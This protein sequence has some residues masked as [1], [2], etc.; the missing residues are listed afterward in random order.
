MQ[1]VTIICDLCHADGIDKKAVAQ[2]WDMEN[3]RWD[4]CR[5]HLE[6]IKNAGLDFEMRSELENGNQERHVRR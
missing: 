3:M 1:K 2:Y 6:D 4:I 5:R